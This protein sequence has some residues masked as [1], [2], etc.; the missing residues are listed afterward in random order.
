MVGQYDGMQYKINIGWVEKGIVFDL[1]FFR[2]GRPE[3]ASFMEHPGG[4][5][6]CQV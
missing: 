6:R 1:N 2:Y 5:T 4:G 3:R